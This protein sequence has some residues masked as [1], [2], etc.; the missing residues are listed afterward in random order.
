MVGSQ[1]KAVVE[2]D[3]G[4]QELQLQKRQLLTQTD[5]RTSLYVKKGLGYLISMFPI[6]TFLI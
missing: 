3:S 5:T 2:N 1:G 6:Q 4:N